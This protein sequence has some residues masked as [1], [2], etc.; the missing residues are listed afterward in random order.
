[1]S[2]LST[3]VSVPAV[4]DSL[5]AAFLALLPR[6][7]RAARLYFRAL[8]CPQRRDDAHAEV[9]ALAWKWFVRLAERGKEVATF[10]TVFAQLAARA[11]GSGRRVAGSLKRRDL[12]AAHARRHGWQFQSLDSNTQE[13]AAPWAEALV[14][15]RR[16]P[17]PEQVVF[18]VDFPA[19]RQT[20]S[21][22][23]RQVMDDLMVGERTETVAR[24]YALS[25]TRISQLRRE[26]H[27]DWE[28]FGG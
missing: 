9:V 16:A 11:V 20:R 23:D 21:A 24:R 18:R 13:R 17:I 14:D 25:P 8:R 2:V 19:W 26:F 10:P 12:H 4:P 5:Q 22:R 3:M 15:N 28:R 6:I 1:M 27:A 7:E